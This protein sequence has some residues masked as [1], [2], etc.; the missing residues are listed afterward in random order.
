MSDARVQGYAKALFE[1][2]RAEGTLD[3]VEDE[4]FRFARSYESSDELRT[5]LSDEG[6]PAAKRQAIIE[7]LLGGKATSTTTQLVS[8]VVGAGR[9]RELPA[10]I[11]KLVAR[12]SSSKN[13]AVAEV[14]SAVPLTDDQQARLKAALAN[15]TG[16]EVNLKIVVDP[17]IIGGLVA[18]VGDTVIDGSVRTRVDQLKSRL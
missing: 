18:T 14:R 17:S 10:I 16:S 7:D 3:E 4:L 1:V 9:A 12:A 11:D 13:L 6:I 8:M 5:A 2:A 15:A